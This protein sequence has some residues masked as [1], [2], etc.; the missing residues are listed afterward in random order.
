MSKLEPDANGNY[1]RSRYSSRSVPVVQFRWPKADTLTGTGAWDRSKADYHGESEVATMLNDEAIVWR[2]SNKSCSNYCRHHKFQATRKNLIG[3]IQFVIPDSDGVNPHE[4]AAPFGYGQVPWPEDPHVHAGT[5]PSIDTT[6]FAKRAMKNIVPGIGGGASYV[7]SL[8]ELRDVGKLCAQ[9]SKAVHLA[10]RIFNDA[11]DGGL[12]LL[13]YQALH[14]KMSFNKLMKVLAEYNLAYA[15]GLRP[16]ISDIRAAMNAVPIVEAKLKDLF[17]RQGKPQVRHYVE[18]LHDQETHNWST[19]DRPNWANHHSSVYEYEAKLC[20][21]VKYTYELRDSFGNP[22]NMKAIE[23]QARA[24]LDYFGVNLNPA[25][26]WD[27]IPWSFVVDW[28]W[29]VGSWLGS[30]SAKNLSPNMCYL[31]G[32]ISVKL[33]QK[34]SWIG[35]C[36]ARSQPNGQPEDGLMIAYHEGQLNSKHYTRIPYLP[37]ADD[38][39]QGSP[40]N[41]DFS[42]WSLAASL[43]A[44]RLR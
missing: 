15:F 21:T 43:V 41:R 42:Q 39:Y 27:V 12:P 31:D 11:K 36:M 25:I 4:T 30:F 8:I 19:G 35:R 10:V 28:L 16:L 1:K 18:N 6:S 34:S 5:P 29:D 14:S 17:D 2:N 37:S 24:Y 40:E 3:P 7:V 20:C 26:I 38:L 13:V 22:I 23:T 44:V 32:C 9:L 33:V